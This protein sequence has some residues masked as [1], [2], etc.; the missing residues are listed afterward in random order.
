[1]G[2]MLEDVTIFS[3]STYCTASLQDSSMLMLTQHILICYFI[4]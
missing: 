3:P 4:L 1:M 2:Q